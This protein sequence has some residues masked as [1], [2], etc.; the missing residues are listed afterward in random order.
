MATINGARAVGLGHRIGSIEPGK[1]AD[2]V[3]H[4]EDVPE[5]QPGLDPIRQVILSGRS[6]T[7]HTVVVDGK[8]IVEAGCSTQIDEEEVYAA[9]RASARGLLRRVHRE[10]KPRWPVI[11]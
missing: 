1:G 9:A 8:V 6:K 5:A 11:E 10:V 3:I 4:R 2:L 7:V